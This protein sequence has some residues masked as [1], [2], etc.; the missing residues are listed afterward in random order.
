MRLRKVYLAAG[1]M[2]FMIS[3]LSINTTYPISM[4]RISTSA[5]IATPTQPPLPSGTASMS[6]SFTPNILATQTPTMTPSRIPTSQLSTK[7][8][9]PAKDASKTTPVVIYAVGDIAECK[10]APLDQ[11]N[12][13]M[14][15]SNLLLKTSGPIFTLGDNSND[16][17]TENDYK[18][19]YN[20]SW[21]R[22][23]ERTY[24]VMG[25]HDV[26]AD[27]QGT[28]YFSYFAGMTGVWG[29]YSLDLGAWHIIILNAE[30]EIGAQGCYYGSPQEK[31]LRADLAATR[32]KCIIALWHQPLFTSGGQKS[33]LAVQS[34]WFDLY[35]YKADIILNGHNHM[36]ERFVPLNPYGVAVAD[37]LRQFVVGTG[38]AHLDTKIKSF[39][40]GE[41]VR[42]AS[43]YGYLKLTLYSNSYQWQFVP[44]SSS[45]FKDM[46]SAFCHRS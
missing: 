6:F 43:S 20:P 26:S 9:A 12:A 14:T 45:S 16:A 25:N 39:A 27:K 15:T 42:D 7:S 35:N 28:A 4:L 18:Y 17:G 21:G 38:G 19:C 32:Q 31:W 11:S 5:I 40:A 30:C 44:S 1:I 37:G 33:Y 34:F 29:H 23:L 13:A 24:P 10:G 22:L 46:G 36:F 8:V 41:V 3:A 2:L